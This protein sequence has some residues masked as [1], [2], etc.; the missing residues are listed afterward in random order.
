MN[1][2]IEMEREAVIRALKELCKLRAIN[3]AEKFREI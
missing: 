3:L 2:A 1:S